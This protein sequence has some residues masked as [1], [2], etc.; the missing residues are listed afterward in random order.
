MTTMGVIGEL[1]LGRLLKVMR[2]GGTG[3]P[4]P[5]PN[6]GGVVFEEELIFVGECFRID[7]AYTS[8]ENVSTKSVCVLASI[9]FDTVQTKTKTSKR[10]FCGCAVSRGVF[11]ELKVQRNPIAS[12][13]RRE[14]NGS[15]IAREIEF[16]EFW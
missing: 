13:Q 8:E 3:S 11:Q 14:L 12:Q 10:L 16:A 1:R 5:R 15:P 6:Q 9:I 7:D 4:G 2:M